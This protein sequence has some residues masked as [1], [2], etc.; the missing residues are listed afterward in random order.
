MTGI[1]RPGRRASRGPNP[2]GHAAGLALDT[3]VPVLV[4]RTDRNVFHHGTLG[5]IRSFGRAGIEVHAVLEGRRAPAARSRYLSRSHPWL[6]PARE[7]D[8]LVAALGVMAERIGRR[9]L[10]VTVDDAGAIFVAENADRLDPW[11]LFPRVAP[12]LPRQVSDKGKLADICESHHLAHPA[13]RAPAT[14]AQ[15]REAVAEL[16]LPLVAKWARPWLLEPATGL[17]ST[18]VVRGLDQALELFARTPQARGPLLLQR[19]IPPRPDGDWFFHGYFDAI[20]GCVMGATGR[21]ERAYP[22]QAGL[23]SL[24]RWL[25]N[26]ELYRLAERVGAAVGFHGI[27]DLDFRYEEETD[28]YH[29]L[30]F[31]PRL[32]AQFRLFTDLA[33]LDLVRAM[34]LD[35]TGRTT[36]PPRPAYGRALLVENYD[37]LSAMRSR[38]D[39]SAPRDGPRRS[40]RGVGELAWFAGDD[41]APFVAMGAVWTARGA[42]RLGARLG[43]RLRPARGADA[44]ARLAGPALRPAQGANPPQSSTHDPDL[45]GRQDRTETRT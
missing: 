7:D 11:Y 5:V 28:T 22:P 44:L 23:T 8:A 39:R 18:T 14:E 19:Q 33:G 36:P 16:G 35:L 34:H 30:D 1:R 4:L 10:L 20:S 45:T 42:G 43:R 15:V 3:D 9:A 26:P 2:T 37:L 40:L 27:L 21:K 32:G 29:L 13:T 41:P 24:G 12:N 17:R 31:N 6:P 38:L 25:E